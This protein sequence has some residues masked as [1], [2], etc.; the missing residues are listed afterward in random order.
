[1]EAVEPALARTSLCYNRGT[2]PVRRPV[3][4]LPRS[5]HE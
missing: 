1:M 2:L 3:V 5:G 4:G